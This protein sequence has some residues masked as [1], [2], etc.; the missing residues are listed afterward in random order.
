MKSSIL[1]HIINKYGVEP[2]SKLV[3]AVK[4]FSQLHKIKDIQAFLDL[5]D[6]YRR[7]IQNYAKIAKALLK[8][9]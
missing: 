8:Q 5:G 9:I 4:E 6:Y 3:L 2:D 1:S 7:F